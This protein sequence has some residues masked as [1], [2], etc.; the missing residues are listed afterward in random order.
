[1]GVF[2]VCVVFVREKATCRERNGERQIERGKK[3]WTEKQRESERH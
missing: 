2:N 3:R 1:M